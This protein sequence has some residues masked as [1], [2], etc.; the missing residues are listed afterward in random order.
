MNRT[1]LLAPALLMLAGCTG[2]HIRDGIWELGIEA[3]VSTTR[4][5]LRVKHLVKVSVGNDEASDAQ[6]AEI[7]ALD[8]QEPKPPAPH[9]DEEGSI[10]DPTTVLRPMYADIRVKDE[11]KG[12]IIQI[13]DSDEDWIWQMVGIVKNSKSVWGSHFGARARLK[14]IVLEGRWYMRWLRDS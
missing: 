13:S 12:P 11:D 5:M 14:P 10:I 8:N 3:Q 9:D 2:Y 1:M 4:E 6:I 7:A